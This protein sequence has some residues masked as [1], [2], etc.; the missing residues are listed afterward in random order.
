VE[1]TVEQIQHQL[2]LLQQ[3][4]SRSEDVPKEEEG[5]V[6]EET[7]YHAGSHGIENEMAFTSGAE[8]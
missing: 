8:R 6:P 5:P 4:I 3:S 7:N 2:E 1:T